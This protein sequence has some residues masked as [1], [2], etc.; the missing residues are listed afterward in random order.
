MTAPSPNHRASVTL[1]VVSHGHGH[2]VLDMLHTFIQSGLLRYW[3]VQ[4][5]VTLNIPE[6]ELRRALQQTQW[7]F[8]VHMLENAHP[9]GFGANHNQASQHTRTDWLCIVNPDIRWCPIAAA[10]AP[11]HLT[12]AL[13]MPNTAN[14]TPIGLY[15]PT[16]VTAEGLRQDYAR[17]LPT[18]WSVALRWAA[19]QCG[20]KKPLGVAPGTS[21]AHWVNG[22]CMLFPSSVYR[23]LGG[24]NERYFMYCEDV[25]ICLRL[26]LQGHQLATIPITVVHAA[27]R[28]TRR[29]R[30]HLYWHIRSLLKLW[31]SS[32]FWRYWLMGHSI[33]PHHT[34]PE[35]GTRTGR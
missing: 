13:T 1:T 7:P 22:A 27:Q 32:T 3:Q 15:C 31:C 14:G 25:D 9:I 10:Q 18:P 28:N 6:P 8:P 21:Q 30:Q 2:Q 34:R 24:F 4:A 16:Q 33:P 20:I 5:I 11:D 12:A 29:Q 23:Q 35:T 19:R 26:Q 17:T